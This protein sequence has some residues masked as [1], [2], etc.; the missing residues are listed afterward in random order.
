MMNMALGVTRQ[1]IGDDAKVRSLMEEVLAE[2][3][4]G[5][6]VF[7]TWTPEIVRDIWLKIIA[8]TGDPDPLRGEK[9]RQNRAAL[10]LYPEARRYVQ[11]Q[12]DPLLAALKLCAAGNA[13]DVMV[14]VGTAPP[15]AM[16]EKVAAEEIAPERVEGLRRRLAGAGLVTW[17]TDNCGEIVFDRLFMEVA[18]PLFD[19][20]VAVITKKVPTVN[21]ALL[22]DALAVG[23]DRVADTVIDNGTDEPL[24]STDLNKVSAQVR[25]LVEAADLV[26]SKGVGNYEMLSEHDELAGKATFLIHAKCHPMC[27]LHGVER[28]QLIVFNY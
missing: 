28:G 21:D 1:A 15:R 2:G 20:K 4:L 13:L 8:L 11:A 26:I 5:G 19:F 10:E 27:E 14:G 12:A 6:D 9:E 24:P 17:F 3:L 22:A 16:I 7:Q 23:L 25:G 18:I